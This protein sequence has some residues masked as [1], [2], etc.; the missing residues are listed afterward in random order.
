MQYQFMTANVSAPTVESF[1]EYAE[2][3]LA[4]LGRLV[5]TASNVRASLTKIGSKQR[6]FELKVEVSSPG[7]QYFAHTVES[8]IT[9]AVDKVHKVLKRQITKH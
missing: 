8:T 4:H 6:Q 9:E 2:L 5:P 7:K 1:Q 3:R